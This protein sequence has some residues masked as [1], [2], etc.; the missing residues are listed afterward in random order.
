MKGLYYEVILALVCIAAGMFGYAFGTVIEPQ[1]EKEE[2]P[3]E[4]R[5][6]GTVEAQGTAMPEPH[7]D[8]YEDYEAHVAEIVNDR[9]KR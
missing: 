5:Y 2:L 3:Q 7:F 4:V 1:K 8:S 9:G 6:Y